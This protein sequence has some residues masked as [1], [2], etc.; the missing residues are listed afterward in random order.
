MEQKLSEMKGKV[1]RSTVISGGI[2]YL[3]P[4]MGKASRQKV[5]KDIED[6][7]LTTITQINLM[8]ICER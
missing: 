3:L 6:K 5:G 8:G 4:L 1:D 7:L 2:S